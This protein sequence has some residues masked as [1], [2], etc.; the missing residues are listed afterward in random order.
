MK[1]CV[2]MLAMLI[3]F[4]LSSCGSGSGPNLTSTPP[5]CTVSQSCSN[6]WTWVGGADVVG[7][8]GTYGTLGTAAS[9]NI[10]GAREGSAIWKDSAGTFWLF[11]GYGVDAVGNRGGLND[12]W[13][14]NSGEWTW[15]GG[16]SLADQPGVYGT[17][18]IAAPSN[19]PSGR[20]YAV[21]W[22]D[23]T[24][25]FWLFGGGVY[26]ND[27]WKYS[28][29]EWTWMSGSSASGQ[30]GI[31]GTLRMPSPGNIP[32]GRSDA[33][34]W[35]DAAGNLWLFGGVGED[36]TAYIAGALN[37]LWR[38]GAG[39]WTWMGGSNLA[40]QPGSYGTMGIAAIDNVPPAR[41]DSAAWTDAAGSFW[42]FGGSGFN[43]LWMYNSGEW[44]WVGGSDLLDQS[45]T[46]GT[47]G[48]AAPGNIPGFRSSAATWIDASGN[49]WLFGGSDSVPYTAGDL[50]DLWKYGAGDWT[51]AG[52]A[53]TTN[54]AGTYGTKGTAA[55]H[56]T[57]GGRFGASAWTDTSGNLWLFG[58]DGL[59]STGTNGPQGTGGELNDLWKYQP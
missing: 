44:T 5:T 59:D 11:G 8:A 35:A 28:N 29:G 9:A 21:S 39:Q 26:L 56:N 17:L 52:G 22:I 54:Q 58:G 2:F 4:Y 50:N 16:S 37:D 43:D 34:G 32:G 18:G 7:Q 36:S 6:Q 1:P 13:K 45:G 30:P 25:N 40:N 41:A 14:Y 42:L 33:V 24:G 20:S 46:Y 19:I 53:D 23:G 57:P 27:L 15:V 31:Y 49:F 47:L 38:Y 3:P 10:P 51:W 48:V 12:L 55:S